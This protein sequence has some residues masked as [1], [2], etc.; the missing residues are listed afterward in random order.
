MS[1]VRV[2]A[3]ANVAGLKFG[4]VASIDEEVALDLADANMVKILADKPKAP[5][6]KRPAAPKAT[7]T[8]PPPP[9]PTTPPPPPEPEPEVTA[10]VADEPRRPFFRRTPD[11][12]ALRRDTVVD[13]DGDDD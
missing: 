2:K 9:P 6:Q 11:A 13:D 8:P 1:Q 5:K 10:E 3:L 7:P 12:P 4:Q